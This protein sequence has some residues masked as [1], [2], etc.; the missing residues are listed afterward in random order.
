MSLSTA[1]LIA[2]SG[3][4]SVTAEAS[5]LS[6]N[7]SA[8]G[9]TTGYTR[10]NGNVI[11]TSYGSQVASITRASNQAVFESMLGATSARATQEA[12]SSGT[13]T[14]NQTIGELSSTDP[15]SAPSGTSPAALISNFTN[16]L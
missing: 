14:L 16:A 13:D 4:S 6:R 15:G 1:S 3:L 8:A 10:K 2:Q 11:T 9:G 12:R 5:V 7:I